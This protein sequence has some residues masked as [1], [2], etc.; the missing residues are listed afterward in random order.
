ME[1]DGPR[2]PLNYQPDVFDHPV[3][4]DGYSPLRRLLLAT[5]V[6]GAEP[7]LLT[8]AEEVDAAIAGGEIAEERTDVVVNAPFLTWKGGQ[9]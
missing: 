8:S 9:R 2:G 5:W 4:S 3:G 1:P 6:G 7:R